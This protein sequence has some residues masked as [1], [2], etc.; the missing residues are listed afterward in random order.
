MARSFE[1]RKQLRK[2]NVRKHPVTSLDPDGSVVVATRDVPKRRRGRP[3]GSRTRTAHSHV[4]ADEFAFL[5]AVAQGIDVAAAARQYLTWP[6]RLPER[7]VLENYTRQLLE[8]VSSGALALGDSDEGRHMARRLFALQPNSSTTEQINDQA[9]I[10][11]GGHTGV[12]H[13]CVATREFT[14]VPTL[15]QFAA[16]FPE[17]MYSESELLEMY[18][19]EFP[20]GAAPMAPT[21][22]TAPAAVLEVIETPAP[23]SRVQ[24]LLEAIDWLS[25]RLVVVPERSHRIEQWVRLNPTQRQSIESLGLRDIGQ[26]VDWIATTGKHWYA[27]VPRFGVAR[28]HALEMWFAKWSLQPRQSLAVKWDAPDDCAG[29]KVLRPLTLHREAWPRHLLGA[30]A[31]FGEPANSLGAQ[32]DVEAL[33]KWLELLKSKSRLTQIAYRRAIERLALWALFEREIA[34]S[35]IRSEHLDEFRK[36]LAHPP[37]HWVQGG[38][39][40]LS[41]SSARWRPLIEPLS[42]ISL[43]LTFAAVKALYSGWQA[44]GYIDRNPVD[45]MDRYQGGKASVD[46]LRSFTQRDRAM[47]ANSLEALEDGPAKRRLVALIVLLEATGLRRE[48][49]ARTSWKHIVPIG[50]DGSGG[51]PTAILR[52]GSGEMRE[53]ALNGAVVKALELHRADRLALVASGK[54]RRFKHVLPAEMP[55]I[56]VLDDRWIATIEK[57]RSE[58]AGWHE[59]LPSQD[60]A[61]PLVPVSSPPMLNS[62]GHLSSSAIYALLKAFFRTCSDTTKGEGSSSDDCARFE[63]ASSQWLRQTSNHNENKANRAQS[64]G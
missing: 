39:R 36:F 44:S 46:V 60:P 61:Q 2:M 10:E 27:K 22:S 30:R 49:L 7:S 59:A 25:E 41:R 8:R 20:D 3:L 56:G 35:S 1:I 14:P 31:S 54:L 52:I 47:I 37:P 13:A 45:E 48:E 43:D 34:L 19:Q 5:R 32:D 55:L 12:D 62:D 51:T 16:Q 23:L 17:D 38:S 33:L 15:D 53:C 29:R 18:A 6:G 58:N 57:R 26:L 24:V 4:T 40:A 50:V 21:L 11:V 63:K 42:E 28:A 64:L 9:R